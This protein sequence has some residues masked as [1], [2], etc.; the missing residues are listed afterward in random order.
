MVCSNPTK[1]ER[2]R[3]ATQKSYERVGLVLIGAADNDRKHDD[4]GVGAMEFMTS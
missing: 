1:K 2:E 4:P 3:R